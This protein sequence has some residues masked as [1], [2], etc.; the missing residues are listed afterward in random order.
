MLVLS[1]LSDHR[2]CVLAELMRAVGEMALT[3]WL[4]LLLT[5][6]LEELHQ[7]GEQKLEL[8]QLERKSVGLVPIA[9]LLAVAACLLPVGAVAQLLEALA[10][11][12]AVLVMRLWLGCLTELLRALG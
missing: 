4:L 9:C 1:V 8:G 7:L 5:R 2:D 3:L 11:V 6:I 12:A 10:E